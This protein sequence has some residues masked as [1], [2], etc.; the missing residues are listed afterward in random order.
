MLSSW[1]PAPKIFKYNESIT[2]LN[3]FP[4]WYSNTHWN[5]KIR[6]AWQSP[7]ILSY[8]LKQY[9]TNE[10]LNSHWMLCLFC[11]TISIFRWHVS[12]W[13]TTTALL[14]YSACTTCTKDQRYLLLE[15]LMKLGN[16]MKHSLMIKKVLLPVFHSE[17]SEK[18]LPI[19]VG[20]SNGTLLAWQVHY[21]TRLELLHPFLRCT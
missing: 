19:G 8:M 18:Y 12:L 20:S 1:F 2:V 6:S 21:V 10:I 4:F 3:K 17:R 11:F 9:T 13:V 7:Y 16:Y 14:L 5:R 15:F